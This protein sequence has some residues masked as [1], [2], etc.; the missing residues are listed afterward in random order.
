M[1]ET[2]GGA[3]VGAAPRPASASGTHSHAQATGCVGVG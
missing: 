3:V 2:G 1:H